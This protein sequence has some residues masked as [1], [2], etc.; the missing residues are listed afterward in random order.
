MSQFAAAKHHRDDHLVFVL[1]KSFRLIHLEIDVVLACLGT[2]ANFLDLG[3]MHVRAVEFLLLLVFELAEVHD[4]ADGRLFVRCHLDQIETGLASARQCFFGRDDP[5]LFAVAGDYP[6]R[7][8]PDLLVDTMLL[9]DGLLLPDSD[10]E[11]LRWPGRKRTPVPRMAR[12]VSATL[13]LGSSHGNKRRAD[14]SPG[15]SQGKPNTIPRTG[16]QR[17][18][19]FGNLG[20]RASSGRLPPPV[21]QRG[22]GTG[23]AL[24]RRQP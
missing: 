19:A 15:L 3:L 21:R 18:Q 22:R 4:P 7:G 2:Q 13:L 16:G 20:K 24:D 12:D 17:Q 11:S 6:D 5:E 1:Q 9:L 10:A 23:L 8:D 14:G